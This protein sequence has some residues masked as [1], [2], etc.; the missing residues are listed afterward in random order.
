MEALI[1]KINNLA[2][3]V[4]FPTRTEGYQSKA[5]VAK[6]QF[7]TIFYREILKQVIKPPDL[8]GGEDDSGMHTFNSDMMVNQLTELMVK[9]AINS[10][11]W[12]MLQKVGETVQ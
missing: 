1:P 2:G 10:K 4:N 6:A 7:L 8:S 3:T 9:K 11:Q 12:N 5:D